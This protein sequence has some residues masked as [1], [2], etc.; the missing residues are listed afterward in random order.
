MCVFFTVA[1]PVIFVQY[2]G[3]LDNDVAVSSVSLCIE[4]GEVTRWVNE[5]QMINIS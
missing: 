3:T 5:V 1:V 2:T 4:S